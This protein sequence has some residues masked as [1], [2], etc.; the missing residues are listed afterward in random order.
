M[1]QLL[2]EVTDPK[3]KISLEHDIAAVNAGIFGE[4]II[5]YE[6]QN[7]HITK[8]VLHYLYLEYEGRSAQINLLIITRKR[9]F[10]KEG[11][12]SPVTFLFRIARI[13]YDI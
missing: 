9:Y 1:E 10:I 13:D 6:L 5:L 8:F 4:N 7:S 12:Y 3:I 11:I 2:A